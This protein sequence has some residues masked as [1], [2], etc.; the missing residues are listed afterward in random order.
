MLYYLKNNVFDEALNRIRHLFDE[1]EEVPV[2]FSGGKDS[3]V[4][5]N[6]AIMVAKEKGRLPVKVIFID[7]EA[8]WDMNIEYIRKVMARIEV[9]PMWMQIPL[10]LF[11]A[12]S[13]TDQWLQCWEEG[14][15]NEW[16]RP[17]ED[18]SL[19][20][21][22]YGTDRFAQLFSNILDVEFDG[23]TVAMLGGIRTEESPT[24]KLAMTVD[25]TYKWIT[26]GKKHNPKQRHFTFYPI[27]D[28]SYTDVWKAIHDNG[29]DYCKIYDYMYRYGVPVSGMRVSNVHHETAVKSL[30]I[31]QEIERENW[32]R[33]TKRLS[34]INTAGR[35]KNS[36]FTVS[37]LPYMF[38]DWEEYRDY[39]LEHLI[40]DEEQK[41]K[42]RRRFNNKPAKIYR[43]LPALHEHYCK[44]CVTAI[45]KNDYHMT[46]I[47]NFERSPDVAMYC[48]WRDGRL[49]GE[50]SKT[51]KY[52]QYEMERSNKSGGGES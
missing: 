46:T 17:K 3:T 16:L 36:A 10:K 9:K 48:K 8:E 45:L 21:N 47:E 41:T 14:K 27:Y 38:K 24:R 22:R 20:V 6:L 32:E 43:S 26:W 18:I 49:P 1:F 2:A 12:T 51:N 37:E 50:L 39:L 29:W 34:G 40:F 5:L 15:D 19:K 35:L 52:Y 28:W 33:L 42:Y 31:M 23:K 4:I 30:Y 7:Q 44:V 25:I 13:T 11:N